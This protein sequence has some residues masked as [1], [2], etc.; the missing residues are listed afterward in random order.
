[1][2]HKYIAH[3][4]GTPFEVN[5]EGTIRGDYSTNFSTYVRSR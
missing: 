4:L 1:M 5:D 3:P 2:A